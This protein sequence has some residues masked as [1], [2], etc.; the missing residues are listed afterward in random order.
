MM[1][2]ISRVFLWISLFMILPAVAFA[3]LKVFG[4]NH[5]E[6]AYN[7]SEDVVKQTDRRHFFENWAEGYLQYKY[8]R[9]GLRFE[10]H[11]A[12]QIFAFD[13]TITHFDLTQRFIEYD[14]GNLDVR[15][16]NFYSLFGRGL[17]LRLFENRQLRYNT[18]TDGVKL[19]FLHDRVDIKV[20]TGQPINRVNERQKIFQAGE[21]R[22]KP[23]Q[24]FHLG[25]SA[26][27]TRPDN[28]E[29]VS[30]GSVFSDINV[31]YGSLYAEYAREDNP[32]AANEGKAL[33]LNAN[34]FLGAFSL[35]GEYKDYDHFRQFEGVL[36]NNPPLVAKEHLFTLL[37][38]H[39]LVQ[40]ADDEQGY[41]VEASYPVIEDGILLANYNF[42]ETHDGVKLYEEYYSQFDW[43]TSFDWEFLGGVGRQ[44]DPSARY[45]N[46]VG[47]VEIQAWDYYGIKA[48]YE[49]QHT[50]KR[51]NDQQFYSHA[52]TLSLSKAPAWSVA[53]LSERTSEQESKKEFWI[54]G[55]VD[56]KIFNNLDLSMVAGTR[57]KGKICV[58]G[59]CVNKPELEGAEVTLTARF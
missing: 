28:K 36:F 8:F 50:T 12:P 24:Q 56:I 54:A 26:V 4:N 21:L 20:L 1:T 33:Y 6:Y 52:L 23:I 5:L 2:H 58:G 51:L 34:L 11:N 22:V 9:L 42:T 47:S 35:V 30:W 14:T 15:L 41:M 37:N 13:Q 3:Q 18:M 48:I 25:G 59:V 46:V 39:Q 19:D 38:R 17:V 40:N 49:H 57:R 7:E 31:P 16:G 53:L 10:I 29:R 44:K 55:Q 27:T 43:Y 45:L 32:N